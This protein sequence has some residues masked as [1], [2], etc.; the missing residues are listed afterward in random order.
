MA[1][2]SSSTATRKS[3]R[4]ATKARPD[5]AEL[6]DARAAEE[7]VDYD[8]Q[9]MEMLCFGNTISTSNWFYS[10]RWRGTHVTIERMSLPMLRFV[11]SM[12]FI[13]FFH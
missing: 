13:G 7:R 8:R 11:R 12:F 9:A 4:L 5:Y 2:E 1:A 10:Y 3:T 6:Q